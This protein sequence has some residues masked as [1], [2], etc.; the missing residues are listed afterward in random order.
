MR[1]LQIAALEF[2]AKSILSAVMQQSHAS[3]AARTHTNTYTRICSN[4]QKWKVPDIRVLS[5]QLW[6]FRF[7]VA[8]LLG[9]LYEILELERNL[10]MQA[11]ECNK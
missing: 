11:D 4:A 8:S 7:L 2:R 5:V 10:Q 9:L 3:V 1:F 6:G